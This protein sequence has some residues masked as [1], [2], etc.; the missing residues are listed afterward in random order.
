MLTAFVI[1]AILGAVTGIPIG[2]VNVAVIDAAYRHTLR[3]AI[4]VAFGGALAD[5]AYALLGIAVVGPLLKQH[6]VLPAILFGISGAVL[7]VYGFVTSRSRPQDP[8]PGTARDVA[9]A[10]EVWSG[11]ILGA[12]LIIMNPGALVTW[13]FIV[14]SYLV[15]ITVAE[16]YAAA[17]GVFVGSISWF[18]TVGYLTHRGRHVL[19]DKMAWIPRVVGWLLMGYGV[20]SLW[21]FVKYFLV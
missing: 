13:V 8:P 18:T 4:A 3:R 20:Y 5:A 15:D 6:P 16:G 14:G 7:I 9:T 17:F 2:P 19:G 21:R 1:G 11:I 10:R 12:S